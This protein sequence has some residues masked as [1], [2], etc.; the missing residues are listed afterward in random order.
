MDSLQAIASYPGLLQAL[1]AMIVT[2]SIFISGLSLCL[3]SWVIPNAFLV[4]PPSQLKQFVAT[5]TRGQKYLLPSGRVIMIALIVNTCL[6]AMHPDLEISADW[7]S[8]AMISGILVV[9]APYEV[10]TI[11]P[12]NDRAKELKKQIEKDERSLTP[13][14]EAEIRDLLTKWA[15]RNYGRVILPLCVG[16]LGM[17][18][19]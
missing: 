12:L 5:F 10:Y 6:T 17:L 19:I 3:S 8:W 18:K 16:L 13:S 9:A 1:R 15:F 4:S 11:F 2:S 14:Q 7:S